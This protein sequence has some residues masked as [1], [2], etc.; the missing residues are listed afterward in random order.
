MDKFISRKNIIFISY[1]VHSETVENLYLFPF[2]A[3]GGKYFFQTRMMI[4]STRAQSSSS[5]EKVNFPP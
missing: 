1:V 5:I 3:T 2:D 4:W